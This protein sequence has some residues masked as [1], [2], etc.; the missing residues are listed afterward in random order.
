MINSN[1]LTE[2][3]MTVCFAVRR[4][5]VIPLVS[6]YHRCVLCLAAVTT[7]ICSIYLCSPLICS[8]MF[9]AFQ[10]FYCFT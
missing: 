2:Y 5:E 7:G 10:H 8:E 9:V 6:Q 3:N 1:V 4:A